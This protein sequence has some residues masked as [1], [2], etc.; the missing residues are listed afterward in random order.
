MLGV[1]I[2]DALTDV[3]NR[4]DSRDFLWVV[5]AVSINRR[6]GGNLA[7]VL[8][9]VSKTLRER[10]RVRR[11]VKALTAEGRLSAIILGSLPFVMA[12]YMLLVR[13]EY[14]G[15]LFSNVIGWAMTL[16]AIVLLIVGVLWMRKQIQL[17]V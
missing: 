5:M 14:I 12:A 6:V 11:Q 7:D 2:E 10:E 13:P 1:P 9:T 3:A 15:L 4:M 16:V 8:R 17:E